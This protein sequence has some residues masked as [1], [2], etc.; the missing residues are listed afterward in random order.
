MLPDVTNHISR[1]L[2][3]L[4]PMRA[5]ILL[6]NIPDED[7]DVIWGHAVRGRPEDMIVTHVIVPPAAIRP[8]VPM[9]LGAVGSNEDDLTTKLTDILMTNAVLRMALQVGTDIRNV[10]ENWDLLQVRRRPPCALVLARCPTTCRLCRVSQTQAAMMINGDLPGIPPKVKADVKAI[11]GLVQRL[12]GKQGR[13]RECRRSRRGCITA[14][15]LPARVFRRTL[16]VGICLA[17]G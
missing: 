5:H 2:E 14:P 8:S 3:V 12:K 11:R 4:S 15:C 7:L 13:F 16:Q 17:S 9:E 1:A 10:M 6:C